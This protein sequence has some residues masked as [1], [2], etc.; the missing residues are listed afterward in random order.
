MTLPPRQVLSFLLRRDRKLADAVTAGENPK[1]EAGRELREL[2]D[3]WLNAMSD[4]YDAQR[5]R[6][7]AELYVLDERFTAY[8]DRS[9]SGCAK[10]LHDAI[11]HWAK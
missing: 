9:V 5:Q 6:G 7:L 3:R 10:F 1:G 8:Y 4:K 2:H 11:C